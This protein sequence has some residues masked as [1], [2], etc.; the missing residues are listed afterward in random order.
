ALKR[1]EEGAQGYVHSR[2]P[3]QAQAVVCSRKEI[4]KGSSA[5]SAQQTQN[6]P[7]TW[8]LSLSTRLNSMVQ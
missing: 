7:K 3:T 6:K 5:S 4:S 8:K 1:P 2:D